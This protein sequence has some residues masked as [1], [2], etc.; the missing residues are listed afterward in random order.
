MHVPKKGRLHLKFS[1][2]PVP[3]K[4]TPVFLVDRR[5]PALEQ[6][7]REMDARLQIPAAAAEIPASVQLPLRFKGRTKP[8]ELKVYRILEKHGSKQACGLWLSEDSIEQAGR[9]VADLWWWL[10]P[11]IWPDHEPVLQKSLQQALGLGARRF[12]LNAPWQAG[13]FAGVKG[14]NLW[15]GPF[16]NIANPLAVKA[17]ASL[18]FSGAIVSPELSAKDYLDLPAHSPLPLGIV[19]EGFWPLCISR[20]LSDRLKPLAPFSSPKGEQAWAHPQGEN[21]WIYPNWKLDIRE[22]LPELQKAGYAMF[23][24]LDETAP[25]NVKLKQRPGIWNWEIGLL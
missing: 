1:A 18:G 12:V 10:S 25:K 13:F 8:L 19:I 16:C 24:H 6:L 7:I 2:K 22:K 15:A 17:M 20:V 3:V 4:G 14:L 11:A 5:E 21:Y 9:S 23:V